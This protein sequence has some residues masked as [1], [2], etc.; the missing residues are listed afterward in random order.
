M[1]AAVDLGI[2]IQK[3]LN[4]NNLNFKKIFD[5]Y[6]YIIIKIIFLKF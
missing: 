4:V 2:M 5:V 1:I 6:N 3:K